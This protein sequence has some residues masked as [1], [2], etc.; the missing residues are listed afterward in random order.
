MRLGL[1][2]LQR[3]AIHEN[4]ERSASLKGAPLF[5]SCKQSDH[6]FSSCLILKERLFQREFPLPIARDSLLERE[7]TE[8]IVV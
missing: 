8:Q 7:T 6:K 1:A 5:K 2:L 3:A 4:P